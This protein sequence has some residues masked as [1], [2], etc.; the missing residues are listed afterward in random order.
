MIQQARKDADFH[1]ADSIRLSLDLPE[2]V[3]A[4]IEKHQSYVA[5]QTLAREVTF[6]VAE[7]GMR[8]EQGKLDNQAVSIGLAKL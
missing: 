1:V 7:T 2:D 8:V 5:E 3:R 4:A 6:G